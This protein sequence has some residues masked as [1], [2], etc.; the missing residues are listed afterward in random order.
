[1]TNGTINACSDPGYYTVEVPPSWYRKII[2]KTGRPNLTAICI[3]ADIVYWYQPQ[4][5]Y[6][7][8]TGMLSGYRPKFKGPVL[9]KSADKFAGVYGISARW[10]ENQLDLLEKIGVVKVEK[11]SMGGSGGREPADK[12][13][14]ISL[15]TTKL[16]E[17]T[18]SRGVEGTGRQLA[19]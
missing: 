3:L 7:E 12:E 11:K 17:I 9:K 6:D 2:S 13:L 15:D 16:E 4:E 10:L 5:V 1:M 8:C 19:N 14:S 18:N